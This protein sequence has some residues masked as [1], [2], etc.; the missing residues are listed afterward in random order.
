VG[1][2]QARYPWSPERNA[3][4]ASWPPKGVTLIA[5]FRAAEKFRPRW[6]ALQ[7]SV[8][9]AL[10]DGL[11]LLAKWITLANGGGKPVEVGQAEVE[12]LAVNEREKPRLRVESNYA[13]FI[14]STGPAAL[15]TTHWGADP[16]YESQVDNERQMPLLLTS[17]YPLGPGWRSSPEGP[18]SRSRHTSCCTTAT[19]ASARAWRGGGCTARWPPR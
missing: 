4:Q 6:G 15:E 19:S 10:Y 5:H 13:F 7:V 14:A 3:P 1:Q 8:H 16:Q 2:P 17:R 9:Y 18:S 11:P 12:I